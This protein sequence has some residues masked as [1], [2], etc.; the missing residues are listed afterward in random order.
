MNEW[1]FIELL[2]EDNN[3]LG[4]ELPIGDDC[5]VIKKGNGY[6]LLTKD[7]ITEG[8]HFK[9]EH[10]PVEYI[11]E[12]LVDSNISDIIAMGGEP[13]YALLGVVFPNKIKR[14]NYKKLIEGIK[15]RL[16]LYSTILVGGDTVSGEKL[17]LSMTIV[18]EGQRY[19]KRGG[20]KAGDKIFISGKLGYSRGGLNEF[21]KNKEI[22]NN[23]AF[24]KYFHPKCRFDL[25]SV[26]NKTEINSMIDISDGFYQ[27]FSHIL[28]SSKKGGEIYLDNFPIDDYL[29]KAAK[30][31]GVNLYDF[32]LNSGEEYELILTVSE[33]ESLKLK[34]LG[35][36]EVGVITEK[37]QS[38]YYMNG[39]QVK[40]K[41][42]S[43]THSF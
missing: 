32:I 7:L 31:E 2:K 35:F 17:T 3:Q 43:Y 21:L 9:L 29:I 28:S 13:R 4:V 38:V 39:K 22:N 34:K 36:I 42:L 40:I 6:L 11:G 15:K 5:A 12:K 19:I 16:S 23:I 14:V 26:I 41:N 18:G 10:T 27:D 30:D 25:I 8:T 24:E 37:I 20:A 33:R 1:E